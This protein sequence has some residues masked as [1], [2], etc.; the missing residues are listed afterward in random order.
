MVEGGGG[1]ARNSKNTRVIYLTR[2]VI[3][4]E[5]GRSIFATLGSGRW[6]FF[7]LCR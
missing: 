7:D 2:I 3:V 1:V 6:A 5:R 4:N